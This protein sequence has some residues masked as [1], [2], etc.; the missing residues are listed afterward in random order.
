MSMVFRWH[1]SRIYEPETDKKGV[2]RVIHFKITP[3]AGDILAEQFGDK[4]AALA[5]VN[6]DD[7]A[8]WHMDEEQEI[9]GRTS[10]SLVIETLTTKNVLG[11][12]TSAARISEERQLEE[13]MV[14]LQFVRDKA[15]LDEA[16][17]KVKTSGRGLADLGPLV[18]IKKAGWL[19]FTQQARNMATAIYREVLGEKEVSRDASQ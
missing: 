4:E 15:G 13:N 8:W 9:E 7:I 1:V 19:D 10:E 11:E 12:S 17:A 18:E 6:S 2:Q 5:K 16:L 14:F 3:Q